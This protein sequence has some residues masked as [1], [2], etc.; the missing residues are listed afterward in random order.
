MRTYVIRPGDTLTSIAKHFYNDFTKYTVIADANNITNPNAIR[1]GQTLKIPDLSI[2]PSIADIDIDSATFQLPPREYFH[3]VHPK[4]MIVLH[5]TA[6]SS[7]SSAFSTFKN[8]RSRVGTPFILDRDGRIYEIFPPRYWAIHLFRHRR[9]EFPIFYRL[10]KRTIPIEIV[11]VG[12]LKPD[13][14][15]R[16]R[17]NWWPPSH[18]IT[19]RETYGTRWA[20][21]DAKEKY[22]KKSFRGIDYFASFTDAQYTSLGKLIDY[23]CLHFNIPK[24]PPPDK[25]ETNLEDM[26][27]FRGIA[28]HLNFRSDKYDIGPAF[29]WSKI[30]L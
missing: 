13:T 23:L 17:L 27:N 11:N 19:G 18:A 5:F 28:S 24:E 7:A 8:N 3:E 26:I 1:V 22:E 15:D 21:K 16:D 4:Q 9:G 14:R 25:L 30:G 12:P 6:G 2:D 20:T 10:E 29:D